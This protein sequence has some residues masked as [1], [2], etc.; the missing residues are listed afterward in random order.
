MTT[1]TNYSLQ[2]RSQDFEKGGAKCKAIAREV[3]K[4][5]LDRKPRPLIEPSIAGLFQ[6]RFRLDQP[7][8]MFLTL[9]RS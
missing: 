9:A 7:S 2:G 3:L 1:V 5:F 8:P 4:N 6:A